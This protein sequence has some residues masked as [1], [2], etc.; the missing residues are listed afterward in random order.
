MTYRKLS[1]D[2]LATYAAQLARWNKW[3]AWR[4]WARGYYGPS[5][6]TLEIET[7]SE[8][9]DEGGYYDVIR[10]NAAYDAEGNSLDYDFSA[11]GWA[12]L[13]ESY[14]HKEG[15]YGREGQEEA[16]KKRREQYAAMTTEERSVWWSEELDGYG[17]PDYFYDDMEVPDERTLD[18]TEEPK[19]AWTAVYVLEGA[20]ETA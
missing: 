18:F 20:A 12:G 17:T 16:S 9:D 14:M 13:Y 15:V 7:E 19:R 11:P 4:D 10:G 2:E 5:V 3:K 8:Y 6:A 1:E